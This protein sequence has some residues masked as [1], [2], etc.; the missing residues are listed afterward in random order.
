MPRSCARVYRARAVADYWRTLEEVAQSPQLRA[1]V[2]SELGREFPVEFWEGPELK[3]RDFLK[4]LG[5]ALALAGLSGCAHQPDETIVPYVNQPP[6]LTLGKPLHFATAVTL[7]GLATGVLVESHEGRPTKIEGNPEHPASLGATDAIAQAQILGL[8]DPDRSRSILQNGEV[9]DWDAFVSFA[10]QLRQSHQKDGG[11]GLQVLAGDITSPS[12]AAQLRKLL[13]EFPVAQWRSYEPVSRDNA[14]AGAILAFGRD[15]EPIYD[16]TR[17]K[18]V[19][20]LDSDFLCNQPGSVRYARE[21]IDARRVR[22][23]QDTMNRLYVVESSPTI[24]GATADHKLAIAPSQI[25]SFAR[26]IAAQLGLNIAATN[27]SVPAQWRA[28]LVKDLQQNRGHVLV[29]AGRE[30]PPIVH[31]IA[32]QINATL[33]APVSFIEPIATND[34]SHLQS[35]RE[36]VVEMKA[37]RVQTLLIIGGNPV[38]D[39]PS[40]F[41][42]ARHLKRVAQQHSSGFAR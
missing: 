3:R 12:L 42:F 31:A 11:A 7:N 1:V 32:H 29:L 15:V 5:A 9:A 20:S 40:D 2:E 8:Y 30:Q 16:F 25:E 34:H 37:G 19:L 18:I 6:E 23:A 21:F 28:A 10:A 17:A 14:R 39:A 27:S 35:L 22:N 24:T 4:L 33:N 41:D 38:Y 36:L 13:A 26:E